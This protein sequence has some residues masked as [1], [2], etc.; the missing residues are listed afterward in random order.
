[1]SKL[2]KVMIIANPVSGKKAVSGYISDVCRIFLDNGWAPT[3][4]ITS[5][6][7]DAKEFAMEHG[8]E[9]DRV[10]AMGGDGTMNEVVNGLMEGNVD[11]SFAFVPSGTTNDFA[12]THNIPSDPLEAARLAATGRVRPIDVCRFNDRYFM[13][14]GACG[15]FADVV[16]TTN[17]DFKNVFGYL[18]Y[19]LDGIANATQLAPKHAK[20]ILDGEEFE[21]DFI[22]AALLSTLSLGGSI[23]SLPEDMV[24]SDDGMFEVMFARAPKDLFDVTE[25]LKEFNEKNFDGKYIKLKKVKN[26]IIETDD[27]LSWSLDGEPYTGCKRIEVEVLKRKLK[28]VSSDGDVTLSEE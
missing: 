13:F 7:G 23:S 27:E 2:N 3:V 11:V 28:L 5:K 22:Y 19:I 25:V 6:R 15:F 17:Q 8:A 9:Y 4:F 21:D 20:F 12:S 24:M 26:G 1:M 18:A 16:N 14:H 10:V